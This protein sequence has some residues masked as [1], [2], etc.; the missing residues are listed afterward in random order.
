MQICIPDLRRAVVRPFTKVRVCACAC[1]VSALWRT[2]QRPRRRTENSRRSPTTN[3][4]CKQRTGRKESCV[5][6]SRLSVKSLMFSSL[7]LSRPFFASVVV[8]LCVFQTRVA[9]VL[10]SLPSTIIRSASCAR[11]WRKRSPEPH[12]RRRLHP[13]LRHPRRC[14]C[15]MSP[16]L[17]LLSLPLPF[18]SRTI[19]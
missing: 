1:C 2:T 19:I 11:R 12:R 8:S 7:G 15:R 9:R 13:P 18:A 6:Q 10:T 16:M 4:R 5:V 17:L 3:V 14:P